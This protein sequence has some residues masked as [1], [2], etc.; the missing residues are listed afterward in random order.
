MTKPVVRFAPSPTGYLHIGG[1]RTALYNWLFSRSNDGEFILRIED[2][3][4]IR[5]EKKFEE[6]ILESMQWLGLDWD[7]KLEYQSQ[8]IDLYHEYAQ[9]LVDAGYTYTEKKENTGAE[10]IIFKMPEGE[11]EFKDIVYKRIV[12]DLSLQDDL[13]IIK[14]DGMPT[15]NF[16]CV[17]DDATMG[18]THVI[19]GDDHISN[20][21]KQLVLYDALGFQRPQLAHVPMIIGEDGSRLSKRHG[22][23]AVSQYREEGYISDAMINYLALL[24]WSPGGNKEIMSRE[25]MIE[26][27][28]LDR[29]NKKSALFSLKKLKWLDGQHIRRMAFEKFKEEAEP[30]FKKKQI[31]L[32]NYEQEKVDKIL[33]LYQIRI[34]TLS[35]LPVITKAFFSE[36]LIQYNKEIKNTYLSD[37]LILKKMMGLLEKFQEIQQFDKDNLENV[38]RKLVEEYDCKAG[39]IIHPLRAIVTGASESAG[40]FEILEILGKDLVI[41]RMKHALQLEI[42]N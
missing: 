24:G 27:F 6:E 25:E 5:S 41:K 36:E 21:P 29:V 15:Y 3:D 9:K 7:R 18:I 31:D 35:D 10:A 19:R 42:Q 22:A 16:A 32:N 17:I 39:E 2:T 4:A 14:S 30:F 34:Q 28:S 33:R 12:F 11:I 40:I 26:L 20:T 8:R 38:L 13:V 1:A 37:P 23:V